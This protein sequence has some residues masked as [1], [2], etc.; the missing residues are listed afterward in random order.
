MSLNIKNP[1]THALV[2]KLAE[3][4]GQS[5]TSAVETAVL[6]Q[7][8]ELE[9]DRSTLGRGVEIEVLLGEIHRHLSAEDR[10]ALWTAEADLYDD[11][12][13]PR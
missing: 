6:R 13:L 8:E 1:R 3:E 10:A 4:T 9:R 2:R 5:Q 7:L 11:A 12:G